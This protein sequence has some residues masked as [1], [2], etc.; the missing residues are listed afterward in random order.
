MNMMNQLTQESFITLLTYHSLRFRT[1]W[2]S[3]LTTSA[4]QDEKDLI[5]VIKEHAAIMFVLYW[6]IKSNKRLGFFKRINTWKMIKKIEKSLVQVGLLDDA[7]EMAKNITG[8]EIGEAN[9]ET[10][11][12]QT[13]ETILV[14]SPTLEPTILE[15]LD[16]RDI[17][18]QG[19]RLGFTMEEAP[20]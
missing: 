16:G 10:A 4:E 13:S 19:C 18:L 3:L 2:K 14:I 6:E 1:L 15:M 11:F 8:D 17:Y 9:I 12:K 20:V 5:E 7:L